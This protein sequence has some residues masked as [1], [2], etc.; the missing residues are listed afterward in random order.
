M[1]I[2]NAVSAESFGQQ[3]S[4]KIIRA[5]FDGNFFK[6]IEPVDLMPNTNW[7]L[8]ISKEAAL[9]PSENQTHPL[10]LISRLAA[11]LGPADLAE[12]FDRY[13]SRRVE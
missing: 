12:N 13:T 2:T 9:A 6:P 7:L 1:A 4:A 8:V 3:S 11:D 5:F 10:E